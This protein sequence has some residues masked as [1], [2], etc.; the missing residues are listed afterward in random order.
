[1]R[2]QSE[3]VAFG[4]DFASKET[5]AIRRSIARSHGEVLFAASQSL[6]G[7]GADKKLATKNAKSTKMTGLFLRIASFPSSAKIPDHVI[8]SGIDGGKSS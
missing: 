8:L 2:P 5:I 3:K 1:M 6:S 7:I 4:G